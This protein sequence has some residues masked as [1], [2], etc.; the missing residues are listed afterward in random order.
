MTGDFFI[1][2]TLTV[3]KPLFGVFL[4]F[5]SCFFRFFFYCFA[6]HCAPRAVRARSLACTPHYLPL[7]SLRYD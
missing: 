2:L 3:A 6:A 4:D 5:F 7:F 1:A